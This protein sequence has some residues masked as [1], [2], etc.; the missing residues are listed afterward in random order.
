MNNHLQRNPRHSLGV[1]VNPPLPRPK[2][3]NGSKAWG[4]KAEHIANGVALFTE[5]D[6]GMPID[7]QM[8]S[9][10]KAGMPQPSFSVD[11]GGK[12]IHH[13]WV[14]A[15]AIPPAQF[16][17][18]QDRLLRIY[19]AAFPDGRPDKSLTKANQV[20]RL[21]GTVHPKTGNRAEIK[22]ATGER[23]LLKE[24]EEVLASSE[25]HF[26]MPSL[27]QMRSATPSTPVE[28]TEDDAK[29]CIACL[30]VLP[31]SEFQEYMPWL[32]VMMS[33][34][35][36]D[37]VLMKPHFIEWCRKMGAAFNEN[38][39]HYKWDTLGRNKSREQRKVGSLIYVAKNYGYKSPVLSKGGGKRQSVPVH[40]MP[41][42]LQERL[43]E[44]SVDLRSGAFHAGLMQLDADQVDRLY[45]HMDSP[46][47]V[48][49]KRS[50]ADA[51]NAIACRNAFDPVEL[52]LHRMAREVP[53]L[54]DDDWEHLDQ[55]MLGMD[56]PISRKFLPLYLM[57]AVARVFDP[58]VAVRRSPVL[59][60]AQGRGKTWLGQVLF[61][62]HYV[63]GVTSLDKD[64]LMRVQNA[65]GL[66]LAELD[67]VTHHD[68]T[69]LKASLL[70]HLTTSARHSARESGNTTAAW[71]F[72]ALPTNHR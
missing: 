60:G 32:Q 2:D 45:I 3:W 8:V 41:Q 35:H 64:D 65:W 23:F 15:E 53:P 40:E 21:A 70:R 34:H 33:C 25:A 66:E 63:Q 57:S 47:E 55:R 20:M 24:L 39:I 10:Q 49:A 48:W 6:S 12:S 71:C 31:P 42:L 5:D 61:G 7:E 67:S 28:P 50:T 72:G 13:Y 26:Q 11:T 22:N 36:T 16:T 51:F 44:I 29:K 58:G 43:G 19:E 9:W 46:E 37:P 68:I 59:V 14:L 30:Q 38:E 52:E 27:E 18:L 54:N 56:D 62:E 69:K 4:A 17:N 1:V